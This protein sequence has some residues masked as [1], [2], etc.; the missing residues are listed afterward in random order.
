M[1]PELEILLDIFWKSGPWPDP[2]LIGNEQQLQHCRSATFND[3]Q[4]VFHLINFTSKRSWPTLRFSE[5]LSRNVSFRIIPC[6]T[7][8]Y[9]CRPIYIQ[10]ANSLCLTSV[11]LLSR[12][13]YDWLMYWS[14][15]FDSNK[16]L[17]I[18]IVAVSIACIV[19]TSFC[20]HF[21]HHSD[22]RLVLW[23]A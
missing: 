23:V 5:S 22:R 3:L 14:F 10:V 15:V 20:C 12:P 8:M 9:A 19:F 17:L 6:R 11:H 18:K 13:C 7:H 4:E 2:G 21:H 16:H 1:L